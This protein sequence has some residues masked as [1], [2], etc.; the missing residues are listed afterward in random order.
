MLLLNERGLVAV[1]VAYFLLLVVTFLVCIDSC[2]AVIRRVVYII[3]G[4]GEF[5]REPAVLY[6]RLAGNCCIVL[7]TAPSDIVVGK[8]PVLRLLVQ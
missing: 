7:V 8:Q 4:V 6:L 5:G 3:C 2:R 1:Q